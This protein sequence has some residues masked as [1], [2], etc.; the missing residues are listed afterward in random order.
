MSP[1]LALLTLLLA[2][3]P[4]AAGWPPALSL[5]AA[6]AG[7]TM[8]HG[9]PVPSAVLPAEP[10]DACPKFRLFSE[11]AS[12]PDEAPAVKDVSPFPPAA[13]P[14]FADDLDRAGLLEAL[15]T[16]LAYWKIKPDSYRITVGKDSFS[17]PA[18]RAAS[19][20]LLEIFSSGLTPAEERARLAAEF[21]AYRAVAD[22]GSGN[23][24]FTGYYEAEIPATRAPTA[25]S[26][27]PLNLRPADLV[28]TT[29]AMGVDFDYGRYV[30]G[31]MK[32]H[33]S[34]GEIYAGGLSGQG[35]EAAW[36]AHPAQIMLAQI[37]GS[38]VLRFPDG[39]LIKIGF[40]G[41]N[42]HAFKSVQRLLMDCGEIPSMNFQDFIAYLSRQENG[43]EERLVSLNPRYIFFRVKDRNARPQ[44]AIG[45]PLVPGRSIA[46][47]P[48]PVPYGLAVVMKTRRP[49]AQPGGG[50][51]FRD[52]TRMAATHDTGSAIR[53]PGRVDIFW[54]AGPVAELEASSMKAS[55]ELYLILPK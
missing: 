53:G 34:S 2:A 15:G 50:I 32:R 52:F 22:D 21:R 11:S 45:T 44:G 9:V 28:K 18:M 51:S 46:V 31:V 54:G 20:R 26:R 41:A 27:Y 5:D 48:K 40:D 47:D 42:G 25:E 35:L 36:S 16:N 14:S 4:A 55:G 33:L 3:G 7:D 24:V 38:G 8:L 13:L 12:Y 49:V 29:P 43:R 19:A 30:D 17:A 37:Q 6:S 39:D 1:A 23:V 10:L